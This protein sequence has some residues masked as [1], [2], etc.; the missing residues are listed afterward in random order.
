[1]TGL[2]Y[3][4]R[5]FTRN[6]GC[7]VLIVASGLLQAQAPSEADEVFLKYL[8]AIGGMER[9]QQVQSLLI[10]YEAS[11]MGSTFTSEERRIAGKLA[12][13]TFMNGAP[14]QAVITTQEAV[15]QKQGATKTP[16]PETLT[17]DMKPMAGLF[18][19]LNLLES[20][21]ALLAG[22]EEVN[23]R[24]AYR[25]EVPG[26]VISMTLFYDAETGLKIREIQTMSMGGNSQ[27]QPADLK[28]YTEYQGLKFPSIREGELQGQPIVFKL[29][30][31][32]VDEG[33][34]ASDFE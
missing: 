25:V 12:L 4:L 8:E 2:I 27:S 28:E 32:K 3:R 22:V 26:E 7:L 29:V 19:E 34:T 9:I 15:Y 11:A 6:L 13:T 5:S 10:K 20:P 31:L 30:E 14:L 17:A 24:P 16:L 18:M 1:M 21:R 23:G 33:V